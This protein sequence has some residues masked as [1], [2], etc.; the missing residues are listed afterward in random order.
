MHLPSGGGPPG[1]CLASLTPTPGPATV[2]VGFAGVGCAAV[3][4]PLLA[5]FPAQGRVQ[6]PLC[7]PT[8][9][10]LGAGIAR[11]KNYNS[12]NLRTINSYN[13]TWVRYHQNIFSYEV[14]KYYFTNENT[15]AELN[16]LYTALFL[17]TEDVTQIVP[18]SRCSPVTTLHACRSLGPEVTSSPS[19]SPTAASDSALVHRGT[20][21]P[22]PASSLELRLL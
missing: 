3:G 2:P 6:N 15:E 1:P 5:V 19:L 11:G 21:S 13:G 14:T 10:Q 16:S 4:P 17:Q 20:A 8:R 7:P 22:V 12:T 9:V 18:P